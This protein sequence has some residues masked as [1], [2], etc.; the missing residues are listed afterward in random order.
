W[1]NATV[2]GLT[3]LTRNASA[4]RKLK[5]CGQSPGKSTMRAPLTTI[6]TGCVTWFAKRKLIARSIGEGGATAPKIADDEIR[7]QQRTSV[8]AVSKRRE[9]RIMKGFTNLNY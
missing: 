7:Q 2:N 9:P 6:S 8:S 4:P 1:M 3:S 5:N